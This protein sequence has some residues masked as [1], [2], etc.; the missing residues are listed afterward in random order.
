MTDIIAITERRV[1]IKEFYT[2]LGRTRS[3]FDRWRN[4][5]KIPKPDGNDPLP[6]WLESTV[7]EYLVN[8]KCE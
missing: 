2:R 3:T 7:V 8:D 4:A 5:G 1:R 6:Y